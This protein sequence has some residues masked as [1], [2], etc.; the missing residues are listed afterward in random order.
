[1]ADDT[2]L[3]TANID[4]F[5]EAIVSTTSSVIGTVISFLHVIVIAHFLTVEEVGLFFFY[6]TAVYL[7][8]QIPK[9]V[10][11]SIRKRVSSTENKRPAFLYTGIVLTI[12]PLAAVCILLIG[13][14]P[15]INTYSMVQITHSGV[16]ATIFAM[17]AMGFHHL[18]H[19]YLS[20]TGDP[21]LAD[22]IRNY[23]GRGSQLLL[24]A[25]GLYLIPTVEA[26][27]I[28]YGSGLLIAGIVFW[29]KSPTKI[30]QP[31]IE[32]ARS[33]Y[34]F[35]KWSVPNTILN[36]F[37]HRFDSLALGFLVSATAVGFYDSSV[38]ISSFGFV[39]AAGLA[40]AANVNLSGL[41]ESDKD[42][43]EP[44]KNILALSTFFAFPLL[45][46]SAFHADT[47]LS[48]SYGPEY[49][50]AIWYLTG[51]IGYQILQAYRMQFEALFNSVDKPIKITGASIIAVLINIITA[52]PL[53]AQLGGIGIV[54]STIVAEVFRLSYFIIQT[55][56]ELGVV[57]IKKDI[58]IQPAII[59]II[60]GVLLIREFTIPLHSVSALAVDGMIIAAL[61]FGIMPMLDSTVK[62]LYVSLRKYLT[63]G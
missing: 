59:I 25:I 13:L 21:G 7:F 35:A 40:A 36:D 58:I 46:L 57:F 9:G 18:L 29:I 24:T 28:L 30:L 31:N 53:V 34:S 19:K 22:E 55:K 63:L 17:L 20:G 6:L 4:L 61:Y 44:F 54:V 15:I 48:L 16:L 60:S 45:V 39:L 52:F 32:K 26:A 42:I 5:Y 1:M 8:S 38:R 41:Y 56:D 2:D 49:S 11:V 43:I 27:L 33:I 12:L 3:D 62:E 50:G 14:V 51:I 10:G 37:Y 23:V 47:I